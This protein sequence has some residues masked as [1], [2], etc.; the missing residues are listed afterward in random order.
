VHRILLH[1][2]DPDVAFLAVLGSPFGD[3]EERGVYRT[4]DGGMSWERVLYVDERSGAADLVMDPV[5]PNKLIAAMWS[6]R[7]APWTFASGGAGSGIHVSY[8]GGSTWTERTE[9]DGLPAGDLGRVGLAIAP[10]EPDVVYA[11]VEAEKSVLLRSEDG[12]RS[13]ES[14]NSEDGVSPRPFYYADIFVDPFNENRLYRLS[15]P[16][17]VSE[18]GGKTFETW[19][20]GELVHVA[21]HA[22][23][24]HPERPDLLINGL[25][26]P[27]GTAGSD[28][29]RERRGCRD[30]P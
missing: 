24:L 9:E 18:D 28:H 27:P 20:S 8:D 26:D 5:N 6:H 12:G 30:L 4:G 15:S 7:R 29:Q 25:V 22:W 16:V 14:V 11:L 19:V 3:S 1:P 23:W 21:P 2:S 10:S 17:D 13:F